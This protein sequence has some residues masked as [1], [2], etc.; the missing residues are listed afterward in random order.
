MIFFENTTKKTFRQKA[1][2]KKGGNE[3]YLQFWLIFDHCQRWL[4]NRTFTNFKRLKELKKKK[5][6]KKK[7]EVN[8]IF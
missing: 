8:K 4:F 2:K 1:E 5:M 6:K 7:V 3:T